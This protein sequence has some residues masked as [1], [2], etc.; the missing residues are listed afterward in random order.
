MQ[1]GTPKTHQKFLNREDG[2]YG[3]VPMRPPRG[4]LNMPFNRTSTPGLYCAGALRWKTSAFVR[5]A[6]FGGTD[7]TIPLGQ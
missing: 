6:F 5:T 1:V 2:T 3:P 4:I 7:A